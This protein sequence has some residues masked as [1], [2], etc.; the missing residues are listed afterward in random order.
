MGR[1]TFTQ[2]PIVSPRS[3]T[4]WL[5]YYAARRREGALYT[6]NTIPSVLNNAPTAATGENPADVVTTIR[7]DSNVGVDSTYGVLVGTVDGTNTTF[8]V[9]AGIYQINTLRVWQQTSEFVET[10]GFTESDPTI[11]EFTFTTAPPVG[12]KLIVSSIPSTIGITLGISQNAATNSIYPTILQAP[13]GVR[14]VFTVNTPYTT[15][16]LILSLNGSTMY[17]GTDQDWQEGGSASPVTTIQMSIAPLTGQ[18]LQVW[19]AEAASG[20]RIE[21]T[22]TTLSGTINGSNTTFTTTSPYV[23]DSLRVTVSTLANT[24]GADF[25]AT[26]P[27]DGTFDTVVAPA[28]PAVVQAVYKIANFNNLGTPH[29]PL[30]KTGAYTI[31]RFLE[32]IQCDA[33]G[34]A[35]TVKLPLSLGHIGWEVGIIKLDA[36]ANTITVDGNGTN[37]NGVATQTISIQFDSPRY[38]LG[39]NTSGNAEWHSG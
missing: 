29:I 3:A 13:N 39:L 8:K 15:G 24:S 36:T 19:Y 28:S 32:Y 31:V 12:A 7:V 21:S 33:T 11:G 30:L 35:F 5:L 37:I 10:T 27:A 22:D 6:E 17:Q 26:I 2:V 14:T 16:T 20:W 1:R 34:G 25:N 18:I 9:S 23:M 4:K 38:I